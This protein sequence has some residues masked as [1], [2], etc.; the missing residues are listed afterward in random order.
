MLTGL[1]R[2]LHTPLLA[3]GLHDLAPSLSP[4]VNSQAKE[5]A[6]RKGEKRGDRR[7]GD[8]MVV[9]RHNGSMEVQQEKKERDNLEVRQRRKEEINEVSTKTC[10][11]CSPQVRMDIDSSFKKCATH[12][13]MCLQGVMVSRWNCLKQLSRTKAPMVIYLMVIYLI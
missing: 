13:T 1:P 10:D 3:W 2:L 9:W 5:R 7:R 12:T 8:T 4:W 6:D 11:T